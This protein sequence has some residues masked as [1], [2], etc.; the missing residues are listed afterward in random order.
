VGTKYSGLGRERQSHL[1][2]VFGDK[3]SPPRGL[4]GNPN[5]RRADVQRWARAALKLRIGS[6]DRA[7]QRELEQIFDGG[8]NLQ[9]L[10]FGLSDVVR[11]YLTG[12]WDPDKRRA[13]K[14]R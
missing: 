6:F 14:R 4:C 10:D 8:R 9:Q 11:Y 7:E 12:H 5:W 3:D 13:G 1:A 2:Y